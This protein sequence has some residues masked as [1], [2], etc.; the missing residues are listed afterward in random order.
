MSILQYQLDAHYIYVIDYGADSLSKGKKFVNILK[1]ISIRYSGDAYS[2]QCGMQLLMWG[3][4]VM[5]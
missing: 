2:F 4:Y 5:V 1:R 3:E